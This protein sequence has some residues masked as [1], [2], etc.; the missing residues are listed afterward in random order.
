MLDHRIEKRENSPSMTSPESQTLFAC[1]DDNDFRKK[2]AIA[3]ACGLGSVIIAPGVLL[4]GYLAQT[5]KRASMGRKGLPEWTNFGELATLGGIS[6]LSMLYLLPASLL[7]V[8]AMVPNVQS[9]VSFSALISRF[10]YCGALLADRVGM[11]FTVAGIHAYLQ[12]GRIS[13]IFQVVSLQKRIL[14]KKSHI[15]SLTLIAATTAIAT[16]VLNWALPSWLGL[17]LGW[18]GNTF[19][20]LIVFYEAGSIFGPTSEMPADSIAT[21]EG[22]SAVAAL[23]ETAEAVEIAPEAEPVDDENTWRP[24]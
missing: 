18:L 24:T 11:A 12:S 23:P 16:A 4:L 2:Y 19:A 1:T 20:Y 6:L 7:V 14:T 21:L 8:L 15:T 13:E 17:P 3:A 22:D 5:M 10:I 9:F